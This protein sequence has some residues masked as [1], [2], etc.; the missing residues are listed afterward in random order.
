MDRKLSSKMSQLRALFPNIWF[1]D[2]SDFYGNPHNFIWTG[3]GNHIGEESAFCYY[4]YPETFGVHPVMAQALDKFGLYA[5]FY[6]AGTVFI[7]PK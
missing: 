5:E 7:Y 2:G 6:D 4:A 3:E 1:K